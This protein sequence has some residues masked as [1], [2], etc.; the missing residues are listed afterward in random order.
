MKTKFFALAFLLAAM[1]AFAQAP[2]STFFTSD[3][4]GT[5]GMLIK[6]IGTGSAA[7]VEIDGATGDIELEVADVADNTNVDQASVCAGG[8]AASLDVSDAQC[9]TFGEVV[10]LINASTHWRAVLVSALRS[11]S[12]NNTMTV[13]AESQATRTDGLTLYIDSAVADWA[14]NALVPQGCLTNIRCYMTPQ[15]KLLENPFGGKRVSLRFFQ[16]LSTFDSASLF[17]VY[18]VKVS[19]KAAGSETVTTVF[20]SATGASTVNAVAQALVNAALP[21]RPHEKMI[22][23]I[24]STA[25]TSA[26]SIQALGEESGVN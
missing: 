20:Q 7:T 2:V 10:D 26:F 11:D 4:A 17:K 5:V 12:T 1:P 13:L 21:G 19:N 3:T 25:A 9:D 22:V 18:S 24:E 8:T 23:R 16:G 14:G 6:Y 15:G